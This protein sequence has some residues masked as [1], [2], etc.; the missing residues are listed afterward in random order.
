[1]N[2]MMFIGI[3]SQYNLDY[4]SISKSNFYL[5]WQRIQNGENIIAVVKNLAKS[6]KYY[7]VTY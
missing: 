4:L 5:M 3:T 1:M 6:G 2:Q 7:W